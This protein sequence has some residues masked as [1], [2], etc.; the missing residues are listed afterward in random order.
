[1]KG[2]TRR[3]FERTAHCSLQAP[4]SAWPGRA[5]VDEDRKVWDGPKPFSIVGSTGSIGT[6]VCRSFHSQLQIILYISESFF[7]MFL[8]FSIYMWLND[9]FLYGSNLYE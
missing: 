4:P 5:V 2:R 7:V 1:L 9:G 3:V 8:S 6:Q